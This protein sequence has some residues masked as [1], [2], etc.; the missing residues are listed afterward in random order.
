MTPTRSD[1]TWRA[2]CLAPARGSVAEGEAELREVVARIP[3]L[4]GDAGPCSP[5]CRVPP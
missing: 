1:V 5:A 2:I 4:P 3:E